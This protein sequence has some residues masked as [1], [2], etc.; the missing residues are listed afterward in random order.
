VTATDSEPAPHPL[1]TAAVAE[2]V[3]DLCVADTNTRIYGIEHPVVLKAIS[4]AYASLAGMLRQRNSQITLSLS[5]DGL[6]FGGLPLETRN[7]HV[8]RVV[9]K[10][11]ALKVVHLRFAPGLKEAEFMSFLNLLSRDRDNAEKA[12]FGAELSYA[13]VAHISVRKATYVLVA[14]GQRVVSRRTRVDSGARMTRGEADKQMVADVAQ[15][16]FK[17]KRSR[18]WLVEQAR[19]SPAQVAK[20]I[21]DAIEGAVGQPADADNAREAIANVIDNIKLLGEGLDQ[22]ETGDALTDEQIKEAVLLVEN[23]IKTRSGQLIGSGGSR[24]V[25]N[26][27]LNV[28]ATVTDPLRSLRKAESFVKDEATLKRTEELIR[29][30]Q[31][32]TGIDDSD[33]IR[34]ARAILDRLARKAGE[35]AARGEPHDAFDTILEDGLQQCV[36]QFGIFG[37]NREHAME[38]LRTF[39]RKLLDQRTTQLEQRAERLDRQVTRQRGV[40]DGMLDSGLVLW[41]ERGNVEYLNAGA[42]ACLR[43]EPLKQLRPPILLELA[44]TTFPIDTVPLEVVEQKEWSVAEY[45]FL[46]DVT[47]VLRDDTDT[48][49]AAIL[50]QA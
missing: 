15:E 37:R 32:R 28:V 23:E 41:D 22:G 1:V 45:R 3:R 13:G 48:P 11:T 36:E 25:I 34:K 24:Q 18:D 47:R 7:P 40:L 10:L 16:L 42:Q 35:E 33:K 20:S 6:M 19:R 5:E 17:Q 8:A 9:A 2:F 27:I 26:E 30:Q 44:N 49:F 21:A 29:T 39:V 43:A 12:D 50:K 38:R 4:N 46:S 14:E 31:A